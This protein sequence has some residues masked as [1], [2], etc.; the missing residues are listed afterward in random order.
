[1]LSPNSWHF[2]LMEEAGQSLHLLSITIFLLGSIE[3]T[4]HPQVPVRRRSE[5]LLST[6]SM[7][8]A[9]EEN[10]N[11]VHINQL[12]VDIYLADCLLVLQFIQCVIRKPYRGVAVAISR[13]HSGCLGEILGSSG[14]PGA[15][16]IRVL[17]TIHLLAV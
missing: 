5:S 2:G 7:A 3:Q 10:A 12:G 9:V 14:K 16:R 1:M 15:D 8:S 11:E 6:R 4:T 13:G 17:G